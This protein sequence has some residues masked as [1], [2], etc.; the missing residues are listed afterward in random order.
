M[1][2]CS[3]NQKYNYSFTVK[4]W[5][6]PQTQHWI[7]VWILWHLLHHRERGIHFSSSGTLNGIQQLLLQT[8]AV[9]ETLQRIAKARV[10]LLYIPTIC[11]QSSYFLIPA[12]SETVSPFDYL[13]DFFIQMLLVRVAI[14]EIRLLPYIFLG[15]D[16]CT[17]TVEHVHWNVYTFM[18]NAH[19]F[20]STITP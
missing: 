15:G 13:E 18:F 2:G 5:K 17:S 9:S 3:F 20:P 1:W 16:R 19:C 8:V 7:P 6:W 4:L 12:H 11:I 14:I 10:K